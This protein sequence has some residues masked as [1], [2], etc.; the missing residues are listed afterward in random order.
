MFQVLND[1]SM[2]VYSYPANQLIGKT[3]DLVKMH[4]ALK[5]SIVTNIPMKVKS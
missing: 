3:I 4:F 5:S 1:L 2:A